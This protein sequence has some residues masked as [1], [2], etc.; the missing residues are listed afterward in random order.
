MHTSLLTRK[1]TLLNSRDLFN[2][3]DVM[4]HVSTDQVKDR[5]MTILC[6][7]PYEEMLLLRWGHLKEKVAGK[8]VSLEGQI[9][10]IDM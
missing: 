1:A 2:I 9:T 7:S 3:T 5:K 8:Y 4:S 6:C 10:V